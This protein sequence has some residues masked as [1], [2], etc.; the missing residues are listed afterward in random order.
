MDRTAFV[1]FSEL[2]VIKRMESV[3]GKGGVRSWRELSISET[4][5][6]LVPLKSEVQ[7]LEEL[8]SRKHPGHRDGLWFLVLSFR[9]Y[10]VGI[11]AITLVKKK[12]KNNKK[13]P[14]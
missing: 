7:G 3:G 13:T 12:K 14:I 1:L 11:T 10:Q 8:H 4:N 2:N 6:C 5:P 9:V